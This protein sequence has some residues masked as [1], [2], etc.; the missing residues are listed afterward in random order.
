[1]N[2]AM[3]FLYTEN[4]AHKGPNEVITALDYYITKE[5]TLN[6]HQLDLYCDN[7]YSQNKNRYLFTY[8]DQLC[9][10]GIFEK[11]IVSYP[12]PGHSMMPI[13]RDFALIERKKKS[14]EKIFTPEFYIELIKNSRNTN[15]FNIVFLEKRLT[16]ENGP[17]D[18]LKVKN[19]KK[20]YDVRIKPNPPYN[21]TRFKYITTF[22]TMVRSRTN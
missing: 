6:Q 19:F 22:S 10:K 4:Y 12:V 11:I 16:K 8:L 15:K 7:C 20:L 9:A 17:E 2:T 18:V 13:D 14:H 3:M 5:K 21:K 1:M